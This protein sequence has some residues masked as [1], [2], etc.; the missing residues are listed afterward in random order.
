MWRSIALII[1]DLLI[2]K[3]ILLVHGNLSQLL[4]WF[5]H[6]ALLCRLSIRFL[7]CALVRELTVACY[8]HLL[9]RIAASLTDVAMHK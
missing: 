4:D 9:G 7:V 3:V 2:R 6:E 1:G 5:A 8:S